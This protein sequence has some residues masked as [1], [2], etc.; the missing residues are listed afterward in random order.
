MENIAII[1]GLVIVIAAGVM[2]AW[3]K[4]QQSTPEE[5]ERLVAEAV[6]RL[7][8][9]A[10][11][12]Y[13]TPGAGQ[14]RYAWVMNRLTKLFPDRDWDTLAEYVEAAV[15]RLNERKAAIQGAAHRNGSV[16]R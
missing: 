8:E 3:I 2:L 13:Q 9:S 5:R 12:L 15:H 16:G 11:Q 4:W 7:V 6:L 1:T 10:E 14:T